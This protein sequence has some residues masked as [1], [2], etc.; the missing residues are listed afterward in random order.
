MSAEP[1]LERLSTTIV[2]YRTSPACSFNDRRQ[3]RSSSFTFQLTMQTLTSGAPVAR[4][5]CPC[6]P[7][8]LSCSSVNVIFSALIHTCRD[9]RE[10]LPF[11]ER[12][13]Q[14]HGP[15]VHFRHDSEVA[16]A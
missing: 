13:A 15:A 10:L 5:T 9:D 11:L 6:E 2:S 7:S 3:S 4:A 8:N 1:S 12:V 14:H 16:H